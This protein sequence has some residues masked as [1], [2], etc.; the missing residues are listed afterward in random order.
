MSAPRGTVPDRFYQMCFLEFDIGKAPR[1]QSHPRGTRN[2]ALKKRIILSAGDF[3][4][5]LKTVR[6]GDATCINAFK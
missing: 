2:A 1:P 5:V 4:Q 3:L 6:S